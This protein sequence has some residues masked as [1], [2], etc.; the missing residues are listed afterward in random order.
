M[1]SLANNI[2]QYS[3][4]FIYF[5]YNSLTKNVFSKN[6]KHAENVFKEICLSLK[7]TVELF[8][9]YKRLCNFAKFASHPKLSCCLNVC[10]EYSGRKPYS[11]YM[12]FIM[13]SW[14]FSVFK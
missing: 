3:Y 11:L 13:H 5:C 10:A 8:V 2:W 4:Q 12:R 1:S 7:I 9:L 14:D 6:I